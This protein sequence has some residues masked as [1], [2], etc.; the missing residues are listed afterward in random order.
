MKE[1]N[2][3]TFGQAQSMPP[4]VIAQQSALFKEKFGRAPNDDEPVYFDPQSAEPEP[5]NLMSLGKGELVGIMTDLG[6]DDAFIYAF[7][8]TG[9]LVYEGNE[10]SYTQEELE[11]WD[12]YVDMHNAFKRMAEQMACRGAEQVGSS[13]KN[14]C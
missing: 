9:M 13:V 5:F 10:S 11:T 2:D 8:K 14:V 1:L 6:I 12:R 7:E 4:E 3:F